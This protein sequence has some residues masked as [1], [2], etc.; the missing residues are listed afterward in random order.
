VKMLWATVSLVVFVLAVAGGALLLAP[1]PPH[2]GAGLAVIGGGLVFG[3]LGA[4]LVHRDTQEKTKGK[5]LPPVNGGTQ[6][7]V[8][9]AMNA[10]GALFDAI[11]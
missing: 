4:V 9:D 1:R 2:V 11:T 6:S 7:A 10:L 5:P 3:V 8:P